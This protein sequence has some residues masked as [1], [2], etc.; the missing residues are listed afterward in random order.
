M[1]MVTINA[2]DG[3]S[4]NAYIARPDGGQGP[5]MLVIQEIFGVN[6]VMRDICDAYASQ[7]YFAV[8]PD[9]FWRQEPGIDITDQSDEEWQKAFEL[10]QGFVADHGV[11]DLKSTLAYLR[12]VDGCSGKVGAVGYCLGGR[13]AYQM[14]T[15]SDADASVGYY[16][17]GI[18]GL[19]DEAG[20]IAHPLMLHIAGEDQFVP[21]TAQQQIHQ[22]LDGNAHVTLHDY[23]EQDH[24]FARPGGAH[25][26]QA[27]ADAANARTASFFQ[28]HLG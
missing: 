10:Y 16:G 17:V 7:G 27:A 5:G 18:E 9:L 25:F 13:L 4:F 19:L 1:T 14:A 3:G 6:K 26:D 20:Q 2:A 11:D 21:K 8:C 22:A 28:R 15:R 23:P 24:A 12:G